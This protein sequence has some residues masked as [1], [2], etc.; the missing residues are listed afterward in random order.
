MRSPPAGHLYTIQ[1]KTTC[2]SRRIGPLA[3]DVVRPDSHLD[4]FAGPNPPVALS[5]APRPV[6]PPV[7]D[8]WRFPPHLGPFPLRQ[9]R[10]LDPEQLFL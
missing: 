5:R 6:R 1:Q 3:H 9:W 10:I 7:S 8:G 4:G 2:T